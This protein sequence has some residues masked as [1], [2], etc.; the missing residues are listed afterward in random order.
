M[1]ESKITYRKAGGIRLYV[2]ETN[3]NAQGVY[4]KLGM[5]G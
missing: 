5:N 1:A 4:K 2:D 3:E